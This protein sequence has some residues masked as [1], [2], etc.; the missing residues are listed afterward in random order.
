MSSKSFKFHGSL[1]AVLTAF[2]AGSP[3]KIISG[4]TKASPAVVTCADHGLED[5]DVVKLT[6]ISSMTEVN[7]G[8]FIVQ[9]STSSTFELAGVD[10]SAYTT[11][12]SGGIIEVGQ[13]SNFCELTAYN[14]QGGTSPD[15]P[16]TSLCST[17][18]EFSVGL[19]DYGTTQF[20]FK[21]APQTTIQ[22]ALKSFY[23]GD[24]AGDV[25]AVKITLPKNGGVMVQLGRVQTM[26]E[27]SG[28]NA[29]WTASATL[30]NTG[31]RED[32]AAS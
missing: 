17:A 31:R 19:P 5:G 24:D 1:I 14:R 13:F 29:I 21:F 2:A 11:Y 4:I 30:R 25:G 15:I 22:L 28:N 8:V 6:N 3:T 12:T 7:D 18:Q 10:S 26:S 27:Q 20:D 23:D 16:E 9:N 32:F